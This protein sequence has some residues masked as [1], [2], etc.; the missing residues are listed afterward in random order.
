MEC[1]GLPRRRPLCAAR[2]VAHAHE[3]WRSRRR[4]RWLGSECR[5]DKELRQRV[6]PAGCAAFPGY[7]G[8]LDQRLLRREGRGDCTQGS[9]TRVLHGPDGGRGIGE[10]RGGECGQ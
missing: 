4:S 9:R 6:E 2:V 1:I 8:G 3:H 10:G 7:E 5:A